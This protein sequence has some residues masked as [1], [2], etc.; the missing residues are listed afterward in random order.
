MGKDD[1]ADV[2]S[3][4][5]AANDRV[6]LPRVETS[7]KNESTSLDDT[8]TS[9]SEERESALRIL[10][11]ALS[12]SDS[13]DKEK[14]KKNHR[15][16]GVLTKS[17]RFEAKSNRSNILGSKKSRNSK[18]PLVITNQRAS[19]K[20][21]S[22]NT[23]I[24][25][26]GTPPT[27]QFLNRD[28]KRGRPTGK[29]TDKIQRN[30]QKKITPKYSKIN[31]V[32]TLNSPVK[33]S[34]SASK[35]KREVLSKLQR[36]AGLGNKNTKVIAQSPKRSIPWKLKSGAGRSVTPTANTSNTKLKAKTSQSFSKGSN[37]PNTPS[38]KASTEPEEENPMDKY[39]NLDFLLN[40][41]QLMSEL[42][43]DPESEEGT[44]D[45][46]SDIERRNIVDLAKLYRLRV[47]MAGGKSEGDF[48][49]ALIKGR[50]S[51]LPKPGQ[52]D[53]LL[54]KMKHAMAIRQQILKTKAATNKR[55]LTDG[56][57]RR[58]M[59]SPAKKRRF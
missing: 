6:P 2:V 27:K 26:K 11:S 20:T 38:K 45:T 5:E 8:A 23:K 16:K 50:E 24:Y 40:A 43:T 30:P 58:N 54:Y 7:S 48:P 47:R 46:A 37:E 9:T 13:S 25:R 21:P 15:L 52:V 32:K 39:I 59:A 57:N 17:L 55:K 49:V 19:P 22:Q 41:N 29:Q 31:K 56:G 35:R 10:R 53:E 1:A 51:S 34:V 4:N 36:K 14:P 28:K 3:E 33:A 12:K 18:S 44:L 42:V